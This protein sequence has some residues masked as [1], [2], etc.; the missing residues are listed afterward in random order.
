MQIV[1]E[2]LGFTQVTKTQGATIP[3]LLTNKDVCVKACTGSGKTLAFVIP[4]I[5][6][7]QNLLVSAAKE[8]GD[9][10]KLFANND[11]LAL[12]IAPSRELAMQTTKVLATFMPILAPHLNFCYFIG[13]DKLEYDLE[14]I[15]EKGANVVVGTPGRLYDLVVH[16]KKL[17]LRKLEILVLDEADKLLDQGHEQHI[18]EL[19][20]GCPKQRRTGLFSATMP[21]SLKNF[22]KIGMRNP[23]FVDVKNV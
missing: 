17:N 16:E 8:E 18:S 22:I 23:Y 5:Q 3:L 1:N 15:N 11:V 6:T 21:S 4:I 10:T 7:L 19:L 13:G 14:R 2:E 20:A 12:L 9:Q